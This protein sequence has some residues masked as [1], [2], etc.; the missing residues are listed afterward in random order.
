M[1]SL[2]FDVSGIIKGLGFNKKCDLALTVFEWFRNCKD[3]DFILN[4]SV[5]AVIIGIL[6]KQGRVSSEASLL[7]N[8]HNDGIDID[9]YGYTSLIT[10][11]ASNGR[12]R[13]VVTFFKKM[14]EEGCKA[15]LITYNVNLNVYGK[16]GMRWNNIMDVV[17]GMKSAGIAPDSYTYN[18]LIS[19]FRRGSLYEEAAVFMRR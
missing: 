16:M 19:C 3:C 2:S 18:T 8:L 17:D 15:T 13:E 14:E 10:A 12:Y 9:V 4:G 11:C 7:H 1:E 5:V 6:G